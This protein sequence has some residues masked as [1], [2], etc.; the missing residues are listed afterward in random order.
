MRYNGLHFHMLRDG[1]ISEYRQANVPPETEAEWLERLTQRKLR[2][3]AKDGNWKV[4]YFLNDHADYRYLARVLEAEPK[5]VLWEQ[6]A[7]LDTLLDYARAAGKAG[8]DPS[9]VK[10]AESKVITEAERLLRKARSKDSVSRVQSLLSKAR[11]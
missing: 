7:F 8:T 5:G 9:L 1:V 2:G 6:C 11:K 3:L 10:Q 4:V